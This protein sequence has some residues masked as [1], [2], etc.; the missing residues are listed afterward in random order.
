MGNEAIARQ[1]DRNEEKVV[2]DMT[3]LAPVTS[4]PLT[5]R[6]GTRGLS[7]ALQLLPSTPEFY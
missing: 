4:E 1:Q 6:G 2:P 3:I 7:V 5:H